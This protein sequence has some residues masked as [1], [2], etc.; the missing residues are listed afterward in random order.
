MVF[1]D[2]RAGGTQRLTWLIGPAKSKELIFAAEIIDADYAR[3]LGKIIYV[4]IT[5]SW[6]FS[7]ILNH[8]QENPSDLCG[9]I[10]DK[11][12]QNGIV[13]EYL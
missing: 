1:I 4:K 7:G 2:L 9:A 6:S 13:S 8:V 12:L 5:L 3:I 10:A 11:I